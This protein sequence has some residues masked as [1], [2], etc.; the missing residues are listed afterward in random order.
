[1]SKRHG[2]KPWLD[3]VIPGYECIRLDRS[4]R[5]GRGCATFVKNGL[6]YRKVDTNSKLECLVVE[7]W[8]SH[9]PISVINYYNP[10]QSLVMSDFDEIME[11]VRCPVIWVGDFNAH[12]PMWG[13]D[14][15]DK[16]GVIIE[17]FLDKY[18]L[19]VLNNGRP[20]RYQ[21]VRNTCSHIVNCFLK[22]S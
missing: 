12:N 3:F 14:H 17:E 22:L 1:M 8:T 15:R 16:N 18:E 20:T 13:S 4:D 10:C 5:S 7:I 19:V 21:I 2:S 9:N 6:Q 11:K